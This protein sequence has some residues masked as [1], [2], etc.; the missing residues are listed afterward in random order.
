MDDLDSRLHDR[1]VVLAEAVPNASAT[2]QPVVLGSPASSTRLRGPSV[3]ALLAV[4]VGAIA[5][6]SLLLSTGRQPATEPSAAPPATAPGAV[7][8]SPTPNP[9]PTPGTS[10][11]TGTAPSMTRPPADVALPYPEGCPAYHLSPRRC[12]YI[13]GWALRQAGLT[14]D[15]ATI[16]LLGDPYCAGKPAACQPVRLGGGSFVVRVRMT[17]QVGPGQDQAIFCG[18]LLGGDRSMLCTDTP[19][20]YVSTPMSGYRDVPCGAEPAPD[21]PCASPL[22]AIAP[23]AQRKAQALRLEGLQVPVDHAGPYSIDIGQA[24]LPNG[25][26][27]DAAITLMDDVRSDVLVPRGVELQIIG[28]DGQPITNA[29]Q[30]G[31]HRGTETVTARLVFNVEE[32]TA[33]VTL[34]FANIVVR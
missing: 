7:A 28:A 8:G 15:Q 29:Y 30:H 3:I 9:S 23:A 21:S 19:R 4:L 18:G 26:L 14:R 25:I 17:P 31:W 27:S 11:L 1:L 10:V 6:G 16:V 13:V 5:L 24:I 34:D 22:P 33:P 32:V 20:I 2:A 12:A